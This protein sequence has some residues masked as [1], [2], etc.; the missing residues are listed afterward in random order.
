MKLFIPTEND[1][2]YLRSKWTGVTASTYVVVVCFDHH[3]GLYILL[4]NHSPEIVHSVLQRTFKME[5]LAISLL[6]AL[7]FPN[8]AGHY[9]WRALQSTPYGPNVNFSACRPSGAMFWIWLPYEANLVE[10]ISPWNKCFKKIWHEKRP[11]K[12]HQLGLPW[13]AMYLAGEL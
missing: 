8:D 10:V 4:P 3:N 6:F 13:V 1:P 7:I 11:W 9:F 5:I 2:R 12:I